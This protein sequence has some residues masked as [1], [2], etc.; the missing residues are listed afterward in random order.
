MGDKRQTTMT[1]PH[2]KIDQDKNKNERM[3]KGIQQ[4]KKNE[5][6]NNN[7]NN[8]DNDNNKNNKTAVDY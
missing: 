7:N 2:T 1:Q 4:K 3:A 5:N 8:D 6:N